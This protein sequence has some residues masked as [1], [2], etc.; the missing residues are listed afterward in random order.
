M[1]KRIAKTI[2]DNENG[3]K[4]EIYT[5][6]GAHYDYRYF[7]HFVTYGWRFVFETDDNYTKDAIEYE[8]DFSF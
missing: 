8:L 4:W 6:D 2:I 5:K 1:A 7:E 3:R